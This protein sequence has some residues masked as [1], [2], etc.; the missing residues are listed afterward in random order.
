MRYIA[1]VLVALFI[2]VPT[3]AQFNIKKGIERVTGSGDG[4]S[5]LTKDEIINGLKEAL[6]VGTKNAAGLASKIDG[7]YKNP[8]IFIPFPP[9]A[10]A[11]EKRLR[12]MGMGK[13]VDEFIETLNR[14]AE[15]ASKKAAP[16]FLSA[17]KG[18]TVQDGMS[19]LKGDDHAAT[20]YLNKAT[21]SDLD[22]SFRPPVREAMDKVQIAKYWE[23]LASAYNKVP[24]VK[25]VN[26]D[27][28]AYI[29]EGAINGLFHLVGKEEEKIRNNPGARVSD[30]LKKVFK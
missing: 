18:M 10:V 5:G 28:E 11:M 9:E 3:Q 2:Y 21:Y 26:P 19:I 29:T 17:I 15:E 1:I 25:K 22:A 27:L 8:A 7:F 20:N 13:Q 14:A 12:S 23:P 16:I 30:L 6:S 4:G 24:M